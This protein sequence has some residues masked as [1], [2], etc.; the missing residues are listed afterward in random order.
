MPFDNSFFLI[1]I[2]HPNFTPTGE[3]CSQLVQLEKNWSPQTLVS[4]FSSKFY[5]F[6]SSANYSSQAITVLKNIQQLLA[7]PS[8]QVCALFVETRLSSQH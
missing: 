1:Q 5:G 2:L 4:R 8:T 3:L 7:N 6:K